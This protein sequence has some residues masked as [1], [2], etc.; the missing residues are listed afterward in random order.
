ML[1]SAPTSGTP[2]TP[3]KR[4]LTELL[5]TSKRTSTDDVITKKRKLSSNSPVSEGS[6]EEEK[7]NRRYSAVDSSKEAQEQAQLSLPTPL[8]TPTKPASSSLDAT[9]PKSS[10]SIPHIFAHAHLL[11]STSSPLTSS[12]PLSGRSDQ[13]DTLLA[14]LTRRFPEVYSVEGSASS[15]TGSS[16]RGPG[17]A[18]LY[19]S[20]PPGIGKTA[21]LSSV[22]KE[23]VEKVD[24]EEEKVRV[25][26]RNCSTVGTGENAWE[27]LGTGLG[28]EWKSMNNAE[29]IKLKGRELFEQGLKD[30]KKYLLILDEI[31]HLVTSTSTTTSA[32]PDLLNALFSLASLPSSPLT[33]IGIANDLT[34]KALN[35]SSIP[36][37]LKLFGKGKGKAKL[38]PL[39]TP[40]KPINLHFAP[41]SWQELVKIVTQRLELLSPS[42]PISYE[43]AL[44]ASP[45]SS[46]ST[47]P[48][49]FPLIDKIALERAA[50]KIATTTG[51]VRTILDVVRKSI[52]LSS[53]TL[54][55]SSLPS[56][57][58]STA[59]KASMKH[60]TLSL[61]SSTGLTSTPSLST[62]LNSLNPNHRFVLISLL[63]ALSRSPSLSLGLETT[64]STTYLSSNGGISLEQAWNV[65]KEVLGREES[66][67]GVMHSSK[68]S[69]AQAIEMVKDLTG[70]FDIAN[71]NGGG[72]GSSTSPNG[73][74]RGKSTTPSPSKGKKGF[75]QKTSMI[76]SGSESA[77]LH[78]LVKLFTSTSTSTEGTQEGK[79][80]ED[81]TSRLCKK[82]VSRE[83][84]DQKWKRK[85]VE[86][87]RDEEKKAEEELEGREWERTMKAQAVERGEL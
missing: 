15:S 61:S 43:D 80:K 82:M 68:D 23:F 16:S 34:L 72:G 2:V 1:R 25:C 42:Y 58:R 28:M 69:F 20:G 77:P 38:D 27:R 47:S 63:I 56:F 50:K 81:E 5:T 19:A 67:K 33:L 64:D 70:F 39:T 3:T 37:P 10:S 11:L 45:V 29:G 8:S 52:S 76:I 9:P 24:G 12:L 71:S 49:S 74:K 59:P 55:G 84:S 22:L 48:K 6:E 75:S 66:L 78:E 21:L 41:Y 85:L 86:M 26:M 79:E 44:S 60:M 35:L 40:T 31:D 83:M 4:P 87:G 62:R 7:E 51:D 57:T 46:T 36:S 17:P 54:D 13:R 65:Y 53:S 73:K 14:F 18:A 32:A 30:G